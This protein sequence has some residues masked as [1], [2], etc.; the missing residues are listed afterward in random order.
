[1]DAKPGS[2]RQ[3]QKRVA[4]E[5]ILQATCDEIVESGLEN[6]ALDVV[7]QRAGVSIR[8][9][10]NY[11]ENRETL[12]NRV[13]DWSEELTLAT[14]G[15]LVPEGLDTLPEIIQAVW[16]SWA[17]QGNVMLA[18]LRIEVASADSGISESRKKRHA[19]I[20]TGVS[21]VRPDLD[22]ATCDRIAS[23]FHGI[24]SPALF[25]R[26]TEEERLNAETASGL[27]GWAMDVLRKAIEAGAD[28]YRDG[29]LTADPCND[30]D[31][32]V[33]AQTPSNSRTKTARTVKRG[34]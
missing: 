14:G 26:L 13:V 18:A 3:H 6:L 1:M 15:F 10:Y 20:A 25:L 32:A 17:A 24:G 7:A 11:F 33:A 9:L 31:G 29:W 8:T 4:R 34:R 12:L 27:T 19:A 30:T 16:L 5:L 22:A 2:L 21:E 23:L 28:P